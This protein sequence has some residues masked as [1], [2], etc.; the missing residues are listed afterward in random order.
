MFS[1]DSHVFIFQT[2]EKHRLRAIVR[3]RGWI[4]VNG[5]LSITSS[6]NST[7]VMLFSI[8]E[9]FEKKRGILS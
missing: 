1:L 4:K 3:F 8:K 5:G 9:K 7:L 6:K 2:G